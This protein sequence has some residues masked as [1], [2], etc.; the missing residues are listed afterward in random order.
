MQREREK[1]RLL[2]IRPSLLLHHLSWILLRFQWSGHI[3]PCES[4]CLTLSEGS[5]DEMSK[6]LG[7]GIVLRKCPESTQSVLHMEHAC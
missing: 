2:G 4:C 5:W 1:Q 6:A 3:F 7:E